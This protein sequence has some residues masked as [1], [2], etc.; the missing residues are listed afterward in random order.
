MSTVARVT[1]VPILALLSVFVFE[2]WANTR[3]IDDVTRDVII[4]DL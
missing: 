2:L 3:Q 1:F 4:F